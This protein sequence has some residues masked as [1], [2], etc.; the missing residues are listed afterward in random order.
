LA[1][2]PTNTDEIRRYSEPAPEED[3]FDYSRIKDTIGESSDLHEGHDEVSASDIRHWC[4]VM[5]DR[6]PL[7]T[8]EEYASKSKYGGIIAPPT[9]VQTWS[10]DPMKE[11]LER[12]VHNDPPFPEDPHNRI[13]GI[14]DDEGY[15]GVVATSQTQEYL[16]PVRPGDTL[17]CKIAIGRVSDYDHFTRMG[18]G[19]WVDMVYTFINQ[20]DEEV[21]VATFR[22]LK[23]R[24]PADTRRLYKG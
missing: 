14:I 17:R 1:R 11:A 10:L 6:N 3:V 7:Y 23:Y 20:H 2:K 13:F 9:M 16:K 15:D 18:V 21:C 22:V 12:F 24:P 5:R 19:R 4:E 8:D